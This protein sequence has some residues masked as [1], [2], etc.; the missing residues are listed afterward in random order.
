VIWFDSPT[1]NSVDNYEGF[2]SIS[3][4]QQLPQTASQLPMHVPKCTAACRTFIECACAVL[5]AGPSLDGLRH[6][7]VPLELLELVVGRQ[8]RVGIVQSH[9]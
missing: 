6:Q 4:S 5:Q 3:D 1:T 2:S 9:N 7:W 8:V